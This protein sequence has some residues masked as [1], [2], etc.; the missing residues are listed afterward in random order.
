MAVTGEDLAGTDHGSEPAQEQATDQFAGVLTPAVKEQ[1]DDL[2]A[3]GTT[4]YTQADTRTHGILSIGITAVTGFMAA[5]AT[6]SAA[7]MSYYA[8][9]SLFPVI[10][11]G[12]L[13]VGGIFGQD[14]VV[15][16]IKKTVETVVPVGS[17]VISGY[18]TEKAPASTSIK[19]ISAVVLLW[20]ASSL[21]VETTGYVAQAWQ[22]LGA[23]VSPIRD[24]GLGV[25]SMLLVIVL[26]GI[27]VLVSIVLSI[28]PDVLNLIPGLN[29]LLGAI[30]EPI[31]A[32]TVPPLLI[33]LL[34]TGL[35]LLAPGVKVWPPA[36]AW[37]AGLAAIVWQ[38][39][40]KGFGWWVNSGLTNYQRIYGSLATVVTLLLWMYISAAI[41]LAGAHLCAAIQQHRG[42]ALEPQQSR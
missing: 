17:D 3:R 1:L 34:L 41:V 28:V 7:S 31:L 21:F 12:V 38:I 4:M 8:L 6:S 40:S 11:F 25:L 39:V 35:Y 19:L 26:L 30:L 36:A 18:L 20:S 24:R 22:A 32:W 15:E 23:R 2:R 13:L 37:A 27:I 33:W 5:R 14:K 10:I 29:A 42:P 16:V 9:F